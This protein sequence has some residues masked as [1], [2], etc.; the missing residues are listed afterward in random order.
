MG[1]I[2]LTDWYHERA[3]D[4]A[5]RPVIAAIGLPPIQPTG[6]INGKNIWKDGGSRFQTTFTPG[7]RHLLRLINTGSEV[8]FKF[9]IDKHKLEVVAMDWT[10]L[11]PY[12]TK[13][14][15][16][17]VGQRLDVIVEANQETGDYWM[18]SV[19]QLTCLAINLKAFNIRGIV[20]YDSSS[21]ADP[22]LSLPNSI[23]DTCTDEPAENLVPFH[24]H[25]VGPSALRENFNTN[26]IAATNEHLALRWEVGAT[27]Y[28]PDKA[29]PVVQAAIDSEV[30]SRAFELPEDYA[31]LDVS[32]VPPEGWVYM[33]V[34]SQLPVSHPMHLHGHDT[35]LLGRGAGLYLKG[36]SKLNLDNPPR[37]DTIQLPALGWVVVA[38]KTDN[39]GAWIFHC[40]I[41]FHLHH[42][43]ARSI[44]ERKS[45]IPGIYRSGGY[46][47]MDRV[48]KN[49]K[50][51]GL[52]N[53]N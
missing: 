14:V 1:P 26:L 16:L 43:F 30:G 36:I 39:P 50:K 32:Q 4:I 41:A 48:C 2:L 21:T 38:F 27:P 6:L 18:R 25:T 23:I 17:G 44:T 22:K 35:Y 29:Y 33:V 37:R 8:T 20:R 15:N 53:D 42:G 45:E 24:H 34:Q 5:A 19:P 10:P 13:A 40:H 28:K 47:E 31:T 11:T 12:T 52:E 49:W 46:S 3:Y 7:K 51:S 9:S